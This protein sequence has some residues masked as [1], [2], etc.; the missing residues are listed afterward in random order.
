MRM[1]R[2][3]FLTVI[4]LSVAGGPPASAQGKTERVLSS[5]GYV[6]RKSDSAQPTAWEMAQ[7]QTLAKRVIEIRSAKAV[8]RRPNT[9]Y[10]FTVIEERYADAG[11]AEKRLSRLREM[12]PDLSPEDDKAFPLRT[13]FQYGVG[14]YIVSTDVSMFRGEMNRIAKELEAALR[15]RRP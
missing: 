10:C 11:S 4:V 13:G 8:P 7:F 2:V 5:F 15:R 12:P 14:V 6:I 1:L 3:L 9:F